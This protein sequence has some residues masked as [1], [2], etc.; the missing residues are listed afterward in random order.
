MKKKIFLNLV[1]GT[2][3]IATPALLLASCSAEASDVKLPIT[4]KENPDGVLVEEVS[5]IQIE[6]TTVQK[7][8]NI[9]ASDFNNV[10]ASLKNTNIG[11]GETNQIVLKANKGFIFEN[12]TNTLESTEFSLSKKLLTTVKDITDVILFEEASAKPITLATAQKLFNIEASD[13]NNVTADLKSPIDSLTNQVVLTAKPGFIFENSTNTLESA[14]FS[15]SKQLAITVNDTPG[16]I[17]VNEAKVKP[18][19]LATAQKLFNV[20]ESDFNNV[21]ATWKNTNVGD[22]QKN[23]MVLTANDGFIFKDGSNILNSIEFTLSNEI[24]PIT[25]KA[26]PEGILAEEVSAD[27]I[28]LATAQ[29]LFNVEAS[30]FNNV[31]AAFKNPVASSTNQIVLTAKA[32]FVFEGGASTL[33]SAEFGLSK[34]LAITAKA[35][36]EIPN[37]IPHAEISASPIALATIQTLFNNVD[38][39]NFVNVNVSLTEVISPNKGNQIVLTA[40]DGFIFENGTNTLES[41][42]FVVGA[43]SK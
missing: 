30:D 20:V 25:L 6:L 15:L 19:T 22:G 26:T 17:T 21:T 31:T 41:E 11:V 5:G 24:L 33:E 1:M 7:L 18:I 38:A 4:V 2:A 29:K 8:F 42:W 36:S 40:K 3:L 10:T 27:P 12:D 34:Q 28:T 43:L 23:Q 35:L 14:E 32:G 16:T 37:I 13:F 39:S 9:E